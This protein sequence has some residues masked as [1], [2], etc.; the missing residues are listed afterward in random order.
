M[1]RVEADEVTY[2][3]HVILRFEIETALIEGSLDVKEVPEAWNAKMEQYLG[4]IPKKSSEGCLQDIHWSMGAFGYFP[5][6]SIG[7]MFC[8][9]MF[10]AFEAKHGDWTGRIEKGD[11]TFVLSWLRENVHRHGRQ[12]SGIELIE[13]I[14]GK[15]FTAK[16]YLDYLEKK[17]S[18]IYGL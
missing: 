12:Y 18:A 17:Y 9:Q 14:S 11:L 8:S 13:K 6:Y 2:P 3:L 1:I 7:N 15:P 4:I 10:P 16:P 5:T